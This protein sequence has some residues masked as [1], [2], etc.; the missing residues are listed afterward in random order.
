MTE[1][2]KGT[3]LDATPQNQNKY[4]SI[5]E[6]NVKKTQN[7][8]TLPQLS[9]ISEIESFLGLNI[10]E[11]S[12][13][14]PKDVLE[15]W[16]NGIVEKAVN[17]AQN[18]IYLQL[19]FSNPLYFKK[20]FEYY[21][22]AKTYKKPLTSLIENFSFAHGNGKNRGDDTHFDIK[23]N[24]DVF[25]TS[26]LYGIN[27]FSSTVETT[28]TQI[29]NIRYDAYSFDTIYID[30]IGSESLFPHGTF[31]NRFVASTDTVVLGCLSK[32][33][34]GLTMI[35]IEYFIKKS[36]VDNDSLVDMIKQD[37]GS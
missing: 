15:N 20:A 13:N 33:M 17:S 3:I 27:V 6:T 23:F 14:I 5:S 29:N 28:Y 35:N 31:F 11:N 26:V 8:S 21:F 2:K 18:D 7:H 30:S 32:T 36:A 12:I 24:T 10:N 4:S 25:L 1:N 22:E 34:H 19:F 37:I 9:D 16:I